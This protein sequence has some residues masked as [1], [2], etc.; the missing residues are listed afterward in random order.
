MK[1]E[2]KAEL[3]RKAF[4]ILIAFVPL[5]SAWHHVGTLIVLAVGT[6]GYAFFEGLRCKGI[7]VPLI[8]AMTD[9]ASRKRDKG[10]FVLGPVT[11]GAGAFLSLLVFPPIVGA[12]AVY[13]LAAGDSVSSLVGKFIGRIRPAF[14][15]GKSV[16]GS[17]ACFIAV[18]LCSWPVSGTIRTALVAAAA[19]P[20]AEAPPFR[21]WDNI[22][23]PLVVGSVV[24]AFYALFPAVPV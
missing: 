24:L 17:I 15:C 8:S 11:L 21:D 4:L 6:A 18:F 9:F 19:A 14:L 12:I 22:I 13:A 1:Q 2:L 7:R 3:V 23:M 10:R 5:M 20:V 16:E